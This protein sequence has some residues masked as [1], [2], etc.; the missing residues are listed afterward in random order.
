[1]LFLITGANNSAVVDN[2]SQLCC[3]RTVVSMIRLVSS[4]LARVHF[5]H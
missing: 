1:M 2:L 5:Y 4:M 3:C